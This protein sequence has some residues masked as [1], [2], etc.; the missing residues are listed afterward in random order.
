MGL[1]QIANMDYPGRIIIIG[2]SREG[3]DTVLY[4]ITGRSPSSQARKIEIDR[5]MKQLR[6]IPTDEKTLKTGQVD[7]LVYTSIFY[8]N[9]IVIGNGKQ[10][11]DIRDAMSLQKNSIEVLVKGHEAWDYEPDNPNFTPRISGCI[12]N[13]GA[14]LGIIKRAPDGSTMRHYFSVP[15]I[16]G[17]GKM[18]A[19]YTG[20]NKNPLPSYSGEPVDVDLEGSTVEESAQALYEALK[21]KPTG[22]DIRVATACLFMDSEGPVSVHVINRHEL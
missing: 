10:T 15:L 20:M 1:E 22:Q 3:H 5:E 11:V 12:T 9:G 16:P 7:L 13:Y 8:E 14:G 6:V 19:T 17:K 2:R 18:I 4:A 21:P